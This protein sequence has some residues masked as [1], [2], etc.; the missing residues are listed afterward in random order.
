MWF[1]PPL[2]LLPR[3]IRFFH[4][5]RHIETRRVL[6]HQNHHKNDDFCSSSTT[7]NIKIYNKAFFCAAPPDDDE[8]D[9]AVFEARVV[10]RQQKTRW[11]NTCC[12]CCAHKI[13]KQHKKHSTVIAKEERKDKRKEKKMY[14]GFSIFLKKEE[15]NQRDESTLL[16]LHARA[17]HYSCSFSVE[18]K[19]RTRDVG[20]N[21]VRAPS[22]AEGTKNAFSLFVSRFCPL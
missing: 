9:Y 15:T 14:L 21:A 18:Q 3:L 4:R 22:H 10:A 12:F 17:L 7:E 1:S 6:L 2:K 20:W 13:S 5:H 19:K 16:S 11:Q 8:N